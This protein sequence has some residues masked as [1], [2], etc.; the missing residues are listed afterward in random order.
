MPFISHQQCLYFQSKLEDIDDG[1]ITN[2]GKFKLEAMDDISL[3][4]YGMDALRGLIL[5]HLYLENY[6]SR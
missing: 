1:K 2:N 4:Q 3:S 5:L 6:Q